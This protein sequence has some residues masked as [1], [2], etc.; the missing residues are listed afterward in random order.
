MSRADERLALTTRRG[1]DRGGHD[2]AKA[3]TEKRQMKS[4]T[5]G[6]TS[7]RGKNGELP[8]PITQ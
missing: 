3:L 7:A 2:G 1:G 8:S 6:L 4:G 5:G